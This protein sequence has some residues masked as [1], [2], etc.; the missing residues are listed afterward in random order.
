MAV[1]KT[2]RNIKEM[3][4]GNPTILFTGS[5][6][7]FYQPVKLVHHK[8]SVLEDLDIFSEFKDPAGTKKDLST[9]FMRFA[10]ELFTNN[11]QDP[12]HRPS[13]RSCLVR[14]PHT[15]NSKCIDLQTGNCIKDPEVKI[16]QRWDG[17][18]PA[19]NY[20]LRHFRSWLINDAIKDKLQQRRR[21]QR[22]RY[23]HRYLL[24]NR[25]HYTAASSHTHD[26][27]DITTTIQ[28]IEN[29]LQKPIPDHRKYA[30]RTIL[31]PYL[32]TIKGLDYN[33]SFGIISDW[34]YNKCDKLER[35]SPCNFD[36]IIKAA[37]NWS[38]NKNWRPLALNKLK[39][40]KPELYSMITP[41]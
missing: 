26:N 15:L 1:N 16:I 29:F 40:E 19:I 8:A 27:N 23:H 41:S 37:L 24:S 38:R 30:I 9:R 18:R 28:W 32:G 36:H 17:Q 10:E 5:G 39:H 13:I 14:V 11:N 7:H 31:A 2:R 35:L 25:Y 20:I 21:Q 3:L 33:Q 6:V 4:G 34:L 22:Q 12:D